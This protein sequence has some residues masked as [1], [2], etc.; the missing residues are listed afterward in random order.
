MGRR[1]VDRDT[2]FNKCR[3][4]LDRYVSKARERDVN[5]VIISLDIISDE[6][7]RPKPTLY[8]HGYYNYFKQRYESVEYVKLEGLKIDIEKWVEERKEERKSIY[9]KKIE[10]ENE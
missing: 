3:D 4:I 5:Y 1:E 10:G 9:K 6:L 2:L 8:A 7:S